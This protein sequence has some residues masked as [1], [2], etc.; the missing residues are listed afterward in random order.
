MAARAHPELLAGSAAS[1]VQ[2]WLLL[3][4]H[5]AWDPKVPGVGVLPAPFVQRLGAAMK[6]EALRQM[7]LRLQFIRRPRESHVAPRAFLGDRR[8]VWALDRAALEAASV[9]SLVETLA[10]AP[11]AEA[12]ETRPWYLVCTHG[13][14][15]R[16]CAKFGQPIYAE[17]CGR[18]ELEGRVW[19]TSHLGGHRFAPTLVTLPSGLCYGQLELAD[20][21]ALVEATERGRIGVAERLRGPCH[22]ERLGQLAWHA[23]ALRWPG[24]DWRVLEVEVVGEGRVELRRRDLRGDEARVQLQLEADAPELELLGSCGDSKTKRVSSARLLPL[25]S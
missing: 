15:D 3:E 16:C 5:G 20:L 21:D 2:T 7:G 6:T 19:Q 18:T 10:C 9:E 14:R 17:L 25:L 22:E 4:V 24:V 8:G 11:R 12:L 23:A 13:V 1:G